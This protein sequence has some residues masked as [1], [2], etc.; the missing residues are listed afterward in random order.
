[1]SD[2]TIRLI[3]EQMRRF[4]F[5]GVLVLDSVPEVLP[6]GKIEQAQYSQQAMGLHPACGS[7]AKRG[8]F[9]C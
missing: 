1:M 9:V 2:S 5:D 8:G 6:V 7:V 4:I 3:D